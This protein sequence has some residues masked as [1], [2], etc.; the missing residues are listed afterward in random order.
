MVLNYKIFK[1]LYLTLNNLRFK[2]DIL[3]YIL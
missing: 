3:K 2:L 1:N